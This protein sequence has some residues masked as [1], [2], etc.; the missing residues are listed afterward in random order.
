MFKFSKINEIFALVLLV[1][2]LT[3][4]A[5]AATFWDD[6]M[7]AGNTGYGALVTNPNICGN[8]AGFSYDTV[9]KVSGAASLKEN[10]PGLQY[11]GQCGGYADRSFPATDDLWS[12]YYV[13]L[14]PGFIVSPTAYTKVMRND[15][16]T[17]L[18][19]W[20]AMG[21]GLNQLLVALQNYPTTGETRNF[22]PN[23]GD[24][25]LTR[26]QWVCIETRIKHNTVGKSDGLVEA[27]KN[28][29]RFMHWPGLEIRKVSQ[30][31]Q[32]AHFVSNRMYRQ[33]G[34][35]SINYDRVAFGNTRIGCIG[36][37]V[38]EPIPLPPLPPA[39]PLAPT[40]L[41]VKQ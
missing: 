39:K 38:P 33:E 19:H 30:G 22:R 7:E 31:T 34:E 35:G 2:F 13:R 32:N 8:V 14:S 28:G 10:F 9:N 17:Q 3:N 5:R 16:G 26:G 25:S 21:P 37:V 12:R 1:T 20:W 15:T 41:Q 36:S 11:T 23:E 24:G 29:V 40:S 18:A 27:Y 4:S 6:E